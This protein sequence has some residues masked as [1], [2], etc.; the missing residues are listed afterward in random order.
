LENNYKKLSLG[1]RYRMAKKFQGIV[2][3]FQV[4]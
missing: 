2:A 4:E 3:K 1:L